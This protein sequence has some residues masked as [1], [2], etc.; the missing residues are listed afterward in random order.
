M[1]HILKIYLRLCP[2]DNNFNARRKRKKLQKICEDIFEKSTVTLKLLPK[3]IG[4]L[5]A[6]FAMPLGSFYYRTLENMKIKALRFSQGNSYAKTALNNNGR[7]EIHWWITKIMSSF[8]YTHVPKSD[9][10][11]TLTQAY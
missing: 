8:Q 9:A 10:I 4:N 1:Y 7:E 5:L 2:N 3:L 11:F 6:A